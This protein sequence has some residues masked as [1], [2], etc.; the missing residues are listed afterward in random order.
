M[1]A[2]ILNSG[3]G[4]RMDD[5]TKDKPKCLVELKKG[6]TILG[7][8]LKIIMRHGIK[9]IIITTG[10]FENQL[11][12]YVAENFPNLDVTLVNNP[13]YAETNAIYSLFLT[14]SL[15]DDDV[16]L[17]HGDMVFDESIFEDLLEDEEENAVLVNKEMELP[18]KDFKGK[19]EGDRITEISVDIFGKDCVALL[20]VYK[21]SRE[22]FLLWMVEIEKFIKK[23]DASVYAENAFKGISDKVKLA[24][25][26]FDKEVCME[27]DNKEDLELA[28]NLLYGNS[29]DN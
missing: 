27:I 29:M 11:K 10:P 28:Q 15:I 1:K 21:F 25:V 16:L 4:N 3:I 22:S 8:Q 2:I 5:L 14:K 26:Y 17:M 18:D 20:P 24:P 6:E 9:N 12:G 19:I 7:Y 23:D 13:K